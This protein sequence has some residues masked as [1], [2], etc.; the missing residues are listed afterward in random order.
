MFNLA[1]MS[2]IQDT[3]DDIGKLGAMLNA[4]VADLQGLHDVLI[5]K[6]DHITLVQDTD[7]RKSA[8][9]LLE[10]T[11]SLTAELATLVADRTKSLTAKIDAYAKAAEPA[12]VFSAS[13]ID[14]VS[15]AQIKQ[16]MFEL[17]AVR[18]DVFELRSE[19]DFDRELNRPIK[20]PTKPTKPKAK[21]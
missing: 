19:L 7:R 14:L 13:F 5:K 12:G 10:L 21:K 11:G 1:T 2:D 8:D 6:I 9:A 15:T 3:N 20:K 17:H 16:L 4:H 18:M